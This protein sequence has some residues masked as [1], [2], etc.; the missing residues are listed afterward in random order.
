MNSFA[1]HPEAFSVISNEPNCE[2]ILRS[3]RVRAL[4]GN[5]RY[6]QPHYNAA[7]DIDWLR[8]YCLSLPHTCKTARKA[9]RL[10]SSA[11]TIPFLTVSRATQIGSL[12]RRGPALPGLTKR[13]PLLS[14][15][16]GRCE[17]PLTTT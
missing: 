7:M 5:S 16:S 8:D 2:P 12:N 4:Y 9:Q 10:I 15:I 3:M 1:F 11:L 14:L 17:C 13:T 6:G